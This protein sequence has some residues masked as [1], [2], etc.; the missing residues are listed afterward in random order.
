M[1]PMPSLLALLATGACVVGPVDLNAQLTRLGDLRTPSIRLIH[2]TSLIRP[3]EVSSSHVRSGLAAQATP[4]SAVIDLWTQGK[5]AFGV[6]VPNEQPGPPRP[7]GET[8]PRG[9]MP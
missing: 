8:G 4:R 5:T 3:P 1:K 6:F 9:S 7:T 2:P